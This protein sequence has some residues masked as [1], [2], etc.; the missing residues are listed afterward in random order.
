MVGR[1]PAALVGRDDSLGVLR[2]A[3]RRAGAGQPSVLIV[4]GETGVGKTRLVRELVDTERIT[5][6]AGACVPMAGDPLPF[7][8]L[9]QALRRLDRTGTLNLQLER[10]PELARL[11]PGLAPAMATRTADLAAA[12]QL[13][14]FQSVL[15]LVDRLGAAAPVLHI[16]EDVHWADRSTL[17][18]VRF[19]A[20]NLTNE[21]AVLLVTVRAD[22]VVPGT[23]LALWVAELA[24]LENAERVELGRLDPESSARLVRQLAGDAADPELVET[25]LARS[26]GNPLFAEQLVL[27]AEQD[28][29]HPAPLPA[30][31]HELLHARVH[32]LSEDTQSVLRSAAVIGRPAAI[33]LLA[34]ATG[35][36]VEQTETLLRSAIDQ[37]VVEIRRDDTIAFRHPAFGE[38][39]Y[40]ELMPGERQRLHRAVAEALEPAEGLGTGQRSSAS[41]DAVSGEL[42]RH[43]FGAGDKER[44]LSAAVAAGWAAERMYAFSDAYTSFT[45]AL[46][47]MEEV[48]DSDH[49]RVRLLKHAGQAASLVGDSAEA[50]RLVE[51]A[52]ALTNDPP[53]RA[54]LLTRLGLIHYRAGRGSLTERCLREAL[55][56][57]P[58]DEESVLVARIH[59]GLALFGAAWSRL[60]IAEDSC[61]RGLAIARAVG[62]R[63]EEGLLVNASGLVEAA[64]GDID[65]GARLLGQALAI[66]AE[67]GNPDDL[68]TAYVNLT[69]VL[70]LGSRVDEV[71]EVAREGAD[72]LTR[73]GLA[74]QRVSFLKANLTEALANAG[75]I[76][77]AGRVIGEA[78][79]QHPRGIMS[80]PVLWQAG[81]IAMT[82]GDLD[83][84]WEWLEQARV[85]VES[86]NAPDSYRRYLIETEAEVELWAGR[87]VAAYDLVIDG[88]DLLR[89]TDEAA[90]GGTLVALGLRALATEAEAHRDRDS[91]VRLGAMRRPLDDAQS[92]PAANQPDDRAVRM[93]AQAETTR[94]ELASDPDAWAGTGVAWAALGR[95][96]PRAYARWREAEARLDS[97][98]DATAIDALRDAHTAAL[99]LG[100][101]RLVQECERLAGWHRI[102][103]VAEPVEAQP[104]ALDKYGLT[105][106]EVEV[107]AG[108]SAGRTNQEIADELFISVKTASVHV[109]NIL[110]KLDVGG[111]QE[112]ARV[113]H[114]LGV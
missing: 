55:A 95:P 21:R 78:L 19:L 86:E 12:S 87:P 70:G 98:V 26:A 13:G 110:R 67:V 14:L 8:P 4:S 28:P 61:R 33:T 66:A 72:V 25:T 105:P 38:V 10:L 97:G 56:L 16:V 71:V 45:R 99:G 1:P 2:A 79:S 69:H 114:R 50:V 112:A 113:A 84:A 11:V 18:L 46:T 106:R 15:D 92:W 44:A 62:A 75:R 6:L 90:Y 51:A 76:T 104:N 42:A 5:L 59:A 111:R 37:H 23:P 82:R 20:T 52:I 34:A 58:A 47:L 107:L 60:D 94:L 96:F 41:S 57:L 24:R 40:A 35:T 85:I 39:V 27:Q 91:R 43:W 81:R 65:S 9:T 68:A 54:A 36:L 93:W 32:A 89:G 80:V 73:M 102:D 63:R 49:D 101:A 64:H 29:G 77:E 88:L 83:E 30:T 53:T 103:L 31:L 48:T 109:S 7:A 3:V 74:R 22:A 108:L 17:D 100:A